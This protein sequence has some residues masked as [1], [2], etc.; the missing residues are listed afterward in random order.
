MFKC[1]QMVIF[2][3]GHMG[4]LV[5]LGQD[6]GITFNVVSLCWP[7]FLFLTSSE[8]CGG[9]NQ[10]LTGALLSWLVVW[11]NHSFAFLHNNYT[12][13]KPSEGKYYS[14]LKIG[15]IHESESANGK[16]IGF[17]EA[18]LS[19]TQRRSEAE[20][21]TL[22]LMRAQTINF[23]SAS[24]ETGALWRPLRQ[25]TLLRVRCRANSS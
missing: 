13:S 8:L 10:W 14:C 3:L 24:R 23:S 6:G 1:R 7:D 19:E 15:D 16:N 4:G 22:S 20:R 25:I 5:V 11:P 2:V 12:S 17:T 18:I 9:K 21:E